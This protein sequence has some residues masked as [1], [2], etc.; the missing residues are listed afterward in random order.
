MLVIPAITTR[1]T[2][3]LDAAGKPIAR[4][5]DDMLQSFIDHDIRLVH[6][7]DFDSFA[8]DAAPDM[9]AIE[10]IVAAGLQLQ[11]ASG[12]KSEQAVQDY[13]E[14]GVASIVLGH[15]A[16]SAPHVLKD[17]CLEYPRHI[18]IALN[19]H[20]QH[21]VCDAH[22]KLQNHELLDLI[23]H[24]ESDGVD[25]LVYQELDADGK[26]LPPN[27]ETLASI[28]EAVTMAVQVAGD[29]RG[30]SDIAGLR[31]RFDSALAGV[32]VHAPFVGDLDLKTLAAI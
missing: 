21:F 1:D 30:N 22:S 7:N 3:L 9:A 19:V 15:R 32:V 5:L 26:P 16:A 8:Q 11:V 17:L 23:A 31:Q 13:L 6:L 4:S 29:F 12:V 27:A 2:E 20:R 14:A 28:A 24:F 18:M 10:A 25:G